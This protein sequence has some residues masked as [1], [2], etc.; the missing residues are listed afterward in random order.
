MVEPG[1]AIAVVAL[2]AVHLFVGSL[3][4]LDVVPRSAWLSAAGGVSVAYVMVH[5]LPELGAGQEAV[6]AQ[7][8]LEL[9][10]DHVYLMA[11]FG[12]A[13]FY[14][15]DLLTRGSPTPSG[16]W[17]FRASIASF[18]VYNAVIGY[19]IVHRDDQSAAG[20]ALFSVALGLHF[21]V[22]DFALRQRHRESYD[23]VARFVLVAAVGVGWMAGEATEISDATLGLL[24]AFIGGGVILNVMKEELPEERASRFWP[25]AAAAATYAA[26][27]QL[28]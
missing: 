15:V 1:A 21:M 7:S 12:L 25:F 4:R 11:L 3:R 8:V 23:R 2:M 27:L 20:L 14:W 24:I 13:F 28:V 10:Q 6:E 17:R 5:L 19:L 16:D 26:L 9:L 22:N 18:A